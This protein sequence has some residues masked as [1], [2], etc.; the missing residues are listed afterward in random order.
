MFRL[1]RF[2]YILTLPVF[3]LVIVSFWYTYNFKI[4]L[5]KTAVII[6][7][8][9]ETMAVVLGVVVLLSDEAKKKQSPQKESMESN[10]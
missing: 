5:L 9:L 3:L 6:T 8:V 10:G 1:P 4:S 7:L 2:L